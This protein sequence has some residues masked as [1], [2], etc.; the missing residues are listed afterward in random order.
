MLW[1]G[2]ENEDGQR[3]QIRRDG[4]EKE[5]GRQEHTEDKREVMGDRD[6]Q[7]KCSEK[8]G[9]RDCQNVRATS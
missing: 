2:R 6:T 4:L 3:L 1:E 9:N 7:K 5:G 8:P